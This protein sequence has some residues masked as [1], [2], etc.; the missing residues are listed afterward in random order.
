[1]SALA[2]VHSIQS[3][4]YYGL[5][6]KESREDLRVFGKE[7]REASKW[8]RARK[9]RPEDLIEGHHFLLF[10]DKQ[11]VKPSHVRELMKPLLEVSAGK[12]GFIE[13]AVEVNRLREETGLSWSD[14]AVKLEA[15]RKAAEEAVARRAVSE[16]EAEKAQARSKQAR[17]EEKLAKEAARDAGKM[18]DEAEALRKSVAELHGTL[19]ALR[20]LVE[21]AKAELASFKGQ[22]AAEAVRLDRLKAEVSET[23]SKEGV[24]RQNLAKVLDCGNEY[25]AIEE[26]LQQRRE[27]VKG[28]QSET[29]QLGERLQVLQEQLTALAGFRPEVENFTASRR[30][31]LEELSRLGQEIAAQKAQLGLLQEESKSL[32]MEIAAAKYLL[33]FALSSK[34]PLAD[35]LLWMFET[36]AAAKRRGR[37][38]WSKV[39]RELEEYASRALAECT[40][41]LTQGRMVP[42]VEAEVLRQ[43]VQ[44]LEKRF[45]T[46]VPGA[47]H[48]KLSRE[49][50]ELSERC[51]KSLPAIDK[52][53]AAIKV[54]M[55]CVKC[56]QPIAIGIGEGES[57]LGVVDATGRVEGACLKCGSQVG[58]DVEEYARRVGEAILRICGG[59]R[60]DV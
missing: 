42:A 26:A 60:Q 33:D 2:Q 12:P 57:Y 40:K 52:M 51:Q 45:T 13:S 4:I 34:S 23:Q 8:A 18:A 31:I 16:A 11:G 14:L 19:G 24:A 20:Q 59:Q 53:K 6:L 35:D 54:T 47:E 49:Y 5:K 21:G 36:L 3:G 9:K 32:R 17:E 38:T 41:L 29:V 1:M 30:R 46:M 37:P 44:T 7:I 25:E 27:L 28:L 58:M 39:E 55:P 48:S 10:L 22:V 56:K 43:Q 15:D 50:S